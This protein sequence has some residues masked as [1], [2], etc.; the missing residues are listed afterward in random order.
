[1]KHQAKLYDSIYNERI[2]RIADILIPVPVFNDMVEFIEGTNAFEI[3]YSL[4]FGDEDYSYDSTSSM[5]IM[6]YPYLSG[7]ADSRAIVDFATQLQR[8]EGITNENREM[9]LTNTIRENIAAR[10]SSF[11]SNMIDLSIVEKIDA[12][13]DV[14][15]ILHVSTGNMIFFHYSC[16]DDLQIIQMDNMLPRYLAIATLDDQEA[17]EEQ[18]RDVRTFNI[19]GPKYRHIYRFNYTKK[20]DFN[21]GGDIVFGTITDAACIEAQCSP[22]ISENI[23]NRFRAHQKVILTA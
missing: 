1:M 23:I 16:V 19:A 2:E 12:D 21:P 17:R 10:I 22:I 5:R 6:P 9:I 8:H 4:R 18:L 3:S 15:C 7:V 20:D 14:G 11:A 13:P